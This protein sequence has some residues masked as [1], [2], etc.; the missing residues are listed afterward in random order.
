VFSQKQKTMA[1]DD[2][3]HRRLQ[4]LGESDFEIVDGQ[5][6][7]RGWDVKNAAGETIG[8]VEELILDAQTR[9]VRYM[10]V[11]L[12]DDALNLDEDRKVLIPIGI[13]QLHEDDDDVLLPNVSVAQ[14]TQLPEYDEDHLDDEVERSI[15]TVLGRSAGTATGVSGSDDFYAHDHFNESNLYQRRKLQSNT[16]SDAGEDSSMRFRERD[17]SAGGDRKGGLGRDLD[18]TRH[19]NSEEIE[20]DSLLSV[21]RDRR[22]TD[23]DPLSTSLGDDRTDDSLDRDIERRNREERRDDPDRVL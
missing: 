18:D 22:D 9:K 11:E 16:G 17:L 10:V 14:L 4:E 5:P 13:A 1:N 23:I 20:E 8:E 21:N 2:M 12:D 3:K 19:Y 6:D 7:I 15:S